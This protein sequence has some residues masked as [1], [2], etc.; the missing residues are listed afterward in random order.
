MAADARRS[1]VLF[2]PTSFRTFR[3]LARELDARGHV[4]LQLRARRGR[5][6]RRGVRAADRARARDAAE[7][8]RVAGLLAL[9]HWVAGVSYFKTALPQRISCETGAPPP[10][11]AALLE[12]LYS[13]GLGELAY[14]NGLDGLPRP[15]FPGPLPARS[16]TSASSPLATGYRA[17]YRAGYRARYLSVRRARRRPG[18]RP[19][20]RRQ[21][22][23][24][25]ARDR[26]PLGPRARAVL[27]RRR[28]R[29]SRARS[30]PPGCLTC[31]RGARSTPGWR[32]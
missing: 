4:T 5:R 21:G 10:A 12:A 7:R 9:L 18:A 31:S 17:R 13:E 27:D 25:R 26:P 3:F 8:E 16:P 2:D 23:G 6:V 28:R 20:R 24:G 29:R 22:L 15:R 11:A 30:R 19:G 14:S 32:R 1:P